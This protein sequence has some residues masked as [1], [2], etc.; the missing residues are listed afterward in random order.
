[1]EP[2]AEGRALSLV[3]ERLRS[4]FPSVDTDTIGGVVAQVHHQYDGRPIRD[5]IPVLVER[6]A[7]E[8]LTNVRGRQRQGREG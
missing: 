5:F 4:Q 8:R 7:A 3:A 2:D 1:M 6:D